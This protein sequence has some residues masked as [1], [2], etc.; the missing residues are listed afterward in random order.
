MLYTSKVCRHRLTALVGIAAF[1]TEGCCAMRFQDSAKA[2][3]DDAVAAQAWRQGWHGGR[4]RGRQVGRH[5]GRQI[6][7]RR[8]GVRVAALGPNI[9]VLPRRAG[10][11]RRGP[12]RAAQ[13][14]IDFIFILGRGLRIRKRQNSRRAKAKANLNILPICPSWARVRRIG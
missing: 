12:A 2:H 10:R 8:G 5:R 1:R 6:G 13:P 9:A 11:G 14:P 4:C 3:G 7:R